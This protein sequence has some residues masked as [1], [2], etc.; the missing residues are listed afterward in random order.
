MKRVVVAVLA[1]WL[2]LAQS[3]VVS[4]VCQRLYLPITAATQETMGN[5]YIIQPQATTNLVINPSPA[6]ATTGY[7][8]MAGSIARSATKQR[9]SAYSIAVTPTSSVNDGAYYG[10][11]SLTSGLSYTASLDFW[12]ELGIPYQ[13][14]FASTGAALQ[15]S[16]VTVT[17]TGAWQRVSVT[18]TESSTTTRRVYVTKNNSSSVAVFYVDGLQV[19]ALSYATTYCD[20]QVKDCFWTGGKY[21]STSTRAS[22]VRSGGRKID[23]AALDAHLVSQS[24]TGMPV[25][26]NQTTPYASL[27]GS[28]LNRQGVQQRSFTISLSTSG[29]GVADWHAN[30][31]ALIDLVKPDLVYPTQ[32]FVLAY[33]GGG[34]ELRIPCYYDGGLEM[35][36]GTRDIETVGVKCLSVDPYWKVDGGGGTALTVQ[37]SVSNANGILQRS[38]AGLW[39]AMGTGASIGA[40]DYSVNAMVVGLDGSLYVAGAFSLMGGVSNT[41]NIAKWDGTSWSALGTG[42]A[43]SSE[44]HA[45]AIGPDGTLYAAGNFSSMGGVSNTAYIAKWNGSAW[46]AMGTG[47]TDVV[48]S[49]KVGND[50]IVYAGGAFTLMGGVASTAR[51]A[52]WNGSAWSAMGTGASTNNVRV[53]AIG[54]DGSVYAAGT[55]ALMGGVANTVAIAKWNGSAWSALST[56]LSSGATATGMVFGLDGVLYVGGVFTTAGPIS[57]VNIAKWNGVQWSVVGRAS[58]FGAGVPTK[59]TLLNDG[60]IA[61][62][63]NMTTAMGLAIP[64]GFIRWNGSA[65]INMDVSFPALPVAK[66]VNSILQ[67]PNGVLY[68]GFANAGTAVTSALTSVTNNGSSQSSPRITIKGPSSGTSRIYQIG[69]IST[70]QYIHLNYTI[71]AGE[72]A[73]LDLT[74]GAISFVSD[75]QG[76]LIGKVLPGSKLSTFSLL[77]GVNSI[78]FYAADSSVVATMTW[79]E[80]CWSVDSSGT[81]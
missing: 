37:Q 28:F 24:G 4:A 69:N 48:Y 27:A 46:S 75:F 63:G 44:V 62:G 58:P 3:Q 30:R 17:G 34:R 65:F 70:G 47:A 40:L 5:F 26:S 41:R 33:D 68:V 32:P 81:T 52:K 35:A 39:A 73:V 77:P 54:P 6:L 51:I 55:Y 19:E 45:L 74:P 12:G 64:D 29:D 14:Y 15:G 66:N 50:G 42:A 71:N 67:T 61:M 25:V 18:F 36:D 10:T 76:N 79:P 56:G 16:A 7:S 38:A 22:N 53:I 21:T 9:R 20:G 13:I 78:L 2:A 72:T 11:V 23:L 8:A 31:Q 49:V 57:A 1:L 59:L 60:S 43:A 80:N